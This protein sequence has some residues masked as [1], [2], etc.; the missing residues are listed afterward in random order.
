[1]RPDQAETPNRKVLASVMDIIFLK[2]HKH[3]CNAVLDFPCTLT[4][5]DKL[6]LGTCTE[7]EL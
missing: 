5:K 2:R 7:Q 6:T 3:V 4:S 1:M